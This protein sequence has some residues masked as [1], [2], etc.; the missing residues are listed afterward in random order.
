MKARDVMTSPAITLSLDTPVP[1]AATFLESH[2]FT[3]AP[4]VDADGHLVGIVSEPDLVRSPVI[5]DWWVVQ[6][7]PDPTIEQ[8]MTPTPTTM[9]SE[10]DL[11]EV[12]T[13]MLDARIRSV[14]IVDNGELV[15]IVTRRDILRVVARREVIFQD[16]APRRSGGTFSP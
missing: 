16:A 4:L 10:D 8:V 1:A 9:R 6:R 3:A 15:G 12:A 2:G 5:P 7:K 13:V 14:P 11:A